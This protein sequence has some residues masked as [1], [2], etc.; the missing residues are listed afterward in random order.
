MS[1]FPAGA[2]QPEKFFDLPKDEQYKKWEELSLEEKLK[3][4]MMFHDVSGVE[5]VDANTEKLE[6]TYE[7]SQTPVNGEY[8]GLI[9]GYDKDRNGL[10]LGI[11][12]NP[13]LPRD[14]NTNWN[15]LMI[16]KPLD[17]ELEEDGCCITLPPWHIA[18]IMYEFLK[19]EG[20]EVT[21]RLQGAYNKW[22][23]NEPLLVFEECDNGLT[24]QLGNLQLTD[25]GELKL[26]IPL[27]ENCN[28]NFEDGA[29]HGEQVLT[30]EKRE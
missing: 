11:T 23:G 4:S 17:I 2:S 9:I 5:V 25:M 20:E 30:V 28:I 12:Q 14:S 21:V 18:T 29:W 27:P 7:I 24:V 26:E 22:G 15:P 19:V 3:V 8:S 13:S 10:W 16:K 1:I 6:I